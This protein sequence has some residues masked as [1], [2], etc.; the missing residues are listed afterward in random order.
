MAQNIQT[1]EK[2]IKAILCQF[3]HTLKSHLGFLILSVR[4]I[5]IKSSLKD[6]NDHLVIYQ[7]GV[8]YGSGL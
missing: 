4:G 2:F 8:F 1:L 5:Y 3:Y 7:L 6:I